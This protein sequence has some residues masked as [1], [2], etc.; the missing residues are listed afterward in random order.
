MRWPPGGQA[1]GRLD[2]GGASHSVRESSDARGQRTDVVYRQ[3]ARSAAVRE[4]RRQLRRERS[5]QQQDSRLL[6]FNRP[7]APSYEEHELTRTTPALQ[8]A[9]RTREEA[10][11]LAV[12]RA[13]GSED[14]ESQQGLLDLLASIPDGDLDRL[15]T[16]YTETCVPAILLFHPRRIYATCA[17]AHRRVLPA[18]TTQTR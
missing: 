16:L 1:L 3:I 5:Q 4:A 6:Q 10:E 11:R 2:E 18:A 17:R 15:R 8:P 7:Q 13:G 14:S 12:R 9:P